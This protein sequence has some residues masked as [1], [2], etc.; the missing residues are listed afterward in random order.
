MYLKVFYCSSLLIIPSIRRASS[1]SKLRLLSS[2]S[3]TMVPSAS[4]N[5]SHGV[6][7]PSL[8]AE[9]WI[10]W[11]LQDSSSQI[12]NSNKKVD[13][14]KAAMART[15]PLLQDAAS[16]PFVCRY[17]T[18]V[19]HPLSTQQ[20]HQLQTYVSQHASLDKLRSKLLE[21]IPQ[22]QKQQDSIRQQIL[23]SF[24]KTELE[25]LYAPFKPPSKGSILDR[26]TSE[27]PDLVNAIDQLW[28]D[29]ERSSSISLSKLVS[30]NKYPRDSVIHLLGTKIASEPKIALVVAD[31]LNKH[32]RIKTTAIA[33]AAASTEKDKKKEKDHDTTYKNYHDFSGHAKYLKDHQVLAIRRG[34][35]Q[36]AIKM[37]FEIDGTK[38]EGCIRYHLYHG[39]SNSNTNSCLMQLK[40]RPDLLD[41]AIHDAW[42]RLL[43]RRGTSRLWKDKCLEAEERASQV[44]QQN[45]R[46]ALLAPPRPSQPVLALD[47]GFQ[48]G[49][50]CAVLEASGKVDRLETVQH[51]G[52]RRE[53]GVRKLMELLTMTHEKQHDKSSPVLVALGNGHGSQDCRKLLQEASEKSNIA[54]D[55]Q[56]VNE[57]GA[58]VWSV[59]PAALK[60]FPKE[61]PAAIGSI[62]IGRRLQNPLF[63]LVKV[64][65]RSLG[66]GMYQ[67]D[68]SEKELD[69]RLHLT[70]VDAVATVGVDLNTCSHQVLEKVP[71]LNKLAEKVIKARPFRQRK[72]LLKVSGLGAKTYEYCAGFL[73]L[74]SEEGA[75]VEPLDNTLVHPESY[76]LAR[77]LLKTFS[78]NLNGDQE[79]PQHKDISLPTQEWKRKWASQIEKASQKFNVS[80]ERVVAVM[81]NL[82]DSM[83][84]KDPRLD[85]ET[86]TTASKEENSS[87]IGSIEGCTLLP[88]DLAE[89]EPLQ[90]AAPVRGIVGTVRNIADFGAFI[91]FGG[92]NDGLLH[93][94]KL[95]PLKLTN[96]LIGQQLGIDILQV[97]NRRVT[98]GV[99]GLQMVATPRRST[100]E[101][102]RKTKNKR[103]G[104]SSNSSKKRSMSTKAAPAKRRRT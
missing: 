81:Q 33:P 95:G 59:T 62:S 17:R 87:N 25:D 96:L 13:S 15:I 80:E 61:K 73:R 104:S 85:D 56:L 41:E 36:K 7:D 5:N 77:W 49:I 31:E 91:D 50:K 83:L 47:P 40:K 102:T 75:I 67:H 34:V 44:F 26:I 32:C 64:P 97:E 11:I 46:R 24:S 76:D 71:G 35:G 66:L 19:I 38:M 63:E 8:L 58:S 37:A 18:D 30:S 27:H 79:V 92:T 53:E 57:A 23:T 48:A 29:E 12:N 65:P 70:S 39:S 1:H 68:L 4:N 10:P 74:S 86:T 20:V 98:L 52:N 84:K 69:E 16:V 9:A 54:V 43:R 51:L 93:T 90:A 60:E 103:S 55:T 89:L 72:D 100:T 22:Q 94:S 21:H 101:G 88:S 82:L 14:T 28:N 78:W 3:N 45:L 42:T 99:N 6:V 2:F